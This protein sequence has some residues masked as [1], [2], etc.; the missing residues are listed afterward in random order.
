VLPRGQEN[1]IAAADNYVIDSSH[2]NAPDYGYAGLKYAKATDN[3]DRNVHPGNGPNPV[4]KV[5]AFWRKDWPGNIKLIGTQNTELPVVTLQISIP[6][7]H[8]LQAKDT[9]KLGLAS[10]FAEMM[11]ED[12]KN[13]T[14]EQMTVALEKLGSSIEVSSTRDAIVFTVECL[15]KNVDKTLALLQERLFNPIFNSDTYSRIQRQTLEGLKQSKTRP[16]VVADDVIA[17][18][19][20]GPDHILGMNENGTESSIKNISL[21]DVQGYYNN[22]ITSKN[23][24]VVIV[25]DITQAEVLSKLAFLNKLPN[26]NIDL[27]AVNAR[28]KEVDKSKIYLVNIPKAAQTEFRIGYV[29][30]LKYDATGEYYK[31]NLMNFALGG[32]FNGRVNINLREDKGWTYG[33]RTTFNGDQYTGDFV[34][35]SGIRADATDSALVEVEKELKAYGAN[36]IKD[37]ELAFMKNAIGQRDALRY[38]TGAQKAGFIERILE[39]NLPADYVEQQNRILKSIT[40]ADIDALAKKW[41]NAD[42]M[43]IVLVGDKARILPGLQKTGYEIVELDTNGKPLTAEGKKGF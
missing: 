43:N 31:T 35:S 33:A 28:P 13:Y 15:K 32:G 30:G 4:V 39:Y 34:F 2:Y 38:E 14:A 24:K 42:K 36:G 5:P 41:I 25:G 6:G 7:G 10:I 9:S 26:K 20:Y 22:Y 1:V 29:T 18:V 27:P 12:T 21:Q 3:F 11:N 23:T 17:A 16:A 19:N 37:E 8:L 40:K